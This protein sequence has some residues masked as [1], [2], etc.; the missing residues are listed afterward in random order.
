MDTPRFVSRRHQQPSTPAS[1]PHG[2][3]PGTRIGYDPQLIM[4]FREDHRRM[5][6]L[7]AEAQGLLTTRDYDGVKRKLG[8]L[9]IVIQDH[10]MLASVKLYVYLTRL[11]SADAARSAVVNNH[12]RVM[13]DHSRLVMDFLRTYSAARLDDS[14]ADQFQG[15]FLAVGAAMVD[16]MESEE[17]GLYPLYRN[18][19]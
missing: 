16:H 5:M 1:V 7:F 13:L 8:E 12:R 15:E 10:L 2:V 6:A 4:R 18:A 19:V 11:Y 9:R 14:Y 17:T 3:A